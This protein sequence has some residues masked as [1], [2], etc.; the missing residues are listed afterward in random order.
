MVFVRGLRTMGAQGRILFNSSMAD[1]QREFFQDISGPLEAVLQGNKPAWRR[2][3]VERTKKA[4]KDTDIAACIMWLVAFSKRPLLI[5]VCA[6]NRGQAGIVEDRAL[7]LLHYN[8]WLSE[9]VEVVSGT[10]R[11]K[12]MPKEVTA[13]IEATSTGAA[14]QGPTPDLLILNELVHVDRWSVMEAHM[15]N[16]DGVPNGIVIVSTNAGIQGSKAHF[17]RKNALDSPHKWACYIW[18][19]KAPWLRD[20]DVEDANRRDPIG[21]EFKRLWKGIWVSGTGD[22]LDE[23]SINAVFTLPGP[24]ER[25]IDW[26]HVAAFDLGIN[27]DHCGIATLAAD[28]KSQKV[29]IVRVQC[30]K[31]SVPNDRGILEV[32]ESFVFDYCITMAKRYNV[33]WFGYDPAAGGSFLA[34]RLRRL[35]IPMR[36][37]TFASEINLTNMA[38]SFVTAVKGEILSSYEDPDGNIRRDFGKFNIEHKP[39]VTYKLKAVSDEFGHAD[40]GTA[41]VIALPKALE[42]IKAPLGLLKDEDIAAAVDVELSDLE[43]RNMPDELKEIYLDDEENYQDEEDDDD[44]I[45][46]VRKRRRSSRRGISFFFDS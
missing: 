14:A 26:R 18:S 2:F 21:K 17:W 22:A 32:D 6:A 39:P 16:A 45:R 1:F 10:I 41:I 43:I 9:L 31:P 3:W 4:S 44:D 20:E 42:L 8:P 11:S 29:E 24:Q 12:A 23:E 35:G 46:P 15:N 19:Q 7:Q 38:K 37:V 25:R 30:I 27:R 5:Q 36:E 33:E 40:V 13:R 28:E 34:Q